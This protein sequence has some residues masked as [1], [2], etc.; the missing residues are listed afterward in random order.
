MKQLTKAEEQ[1]MQILWIKGP[2]FLREMVEAFP[3]P[4]P[5]QNSVA[6]I[7]KILVEKGFVTINIYSRLHQYVAAV[8]KE[9]Y[10]QKNMKQMIKGYFDNSFA[11]AVSFMVKEKNLTVEELEVLLEQIKNEQKQK[12]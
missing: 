9:A 10:T 8:S 2:L 4:K 5:H 7:L 12:K 1:I 6:T 11:N 3:E